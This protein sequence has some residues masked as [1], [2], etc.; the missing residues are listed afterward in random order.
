M[1]L[2]T[3][4]RSD[5]PEEQQGRE[6]IEAMIRIHY[7][8]H[9]AAERHG[10]ADDAQLLYENT[11]GRLSAARQ[12]LTDPGRGL[13]RDDAPSIRQTL[14]DQRKPIDPRRDDQ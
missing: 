3:D 5:S 13:A 2:V 9:E 11:I 10:Y 7:L 14:A 8:Q 6:R 12:R 1:D 4:A